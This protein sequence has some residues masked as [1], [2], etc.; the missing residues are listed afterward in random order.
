M[1]ATASLAPA[2]WSK[3]GPA[4]WPACRVPMI[5]S[6]PREG[7]A[8]QKL[9]T[10]T[11]SLKS[12][13]ARWLEKLNLLCPNRMNSSCIAENRTQTCSLQKIQELGGL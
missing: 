2:V 13:G 6:M 4:T 1:T 7:R 12:S 9:N 5:L 3:D 8:G 11:L 10:N